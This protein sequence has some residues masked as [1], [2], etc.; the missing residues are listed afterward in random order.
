[1]YKPNCKAQ[2]TA[3]FSIS[4]LISEIWTFNAKKW[5]YFLNKGPNKKGV[6]RKKV[7]EFVFK[8]FKGVKKIWFLSKFSFF[9]NTLWI[10]FFTSQPRIYLLF[11]LLVD[12]SQKHPFRIILEGGQWSWPQNSNKP[13]KYGGYRE[14][15]TQSGTYI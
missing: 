14:N 15:C 13:W 12:L 5:W 2:A 10:F 7:L 4:A 3:T 1:M 9:W 8:H 11:G 6:L